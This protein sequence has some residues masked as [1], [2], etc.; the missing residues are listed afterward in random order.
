METNREREYLLPDQMVGITA[1]ALCGVDEPT[2]IGVMRTWFLQNYETPE[3]NTPYD[4]ADGGYVYI[5]GGPYDPREE[6]EKEFADIIPSA[7]INK[8]A[9]ELRALSADWTGKPGSRDLVDYFVND[10]ADLNFYNG[11]QAAIHDITTLIES[12]VDPSV[13]AS[14][15]RLIYANI[16]TVLESFLSDAFIVTVLGEPD[17]IRKFVETTRRYKKEKIRVSEIYRQMDKLKEKVRI[18]LGKVIWHNLPEV[19]GMYK[20]TLG[21]DFP[22]NLKNLFGAITVRHDIVHRNGKTKSGKEHKISLD[23]IGA[24]LRGVDT[25]VSGINTQLGL[26]KLLSEESLKPMD[27]E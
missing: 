8:L 1:G 6:L 27:S 23:E 16:I 5:W 21:I 12:D 10:V 22:G 17:A 24:L 25:F 3:E 19:K 9:D 2:Q 20:N 7:T 13:R 26:R 14:F 15:N 18:S 11:F 4:S